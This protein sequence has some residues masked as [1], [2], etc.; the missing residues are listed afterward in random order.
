MLCGTA[1]QAEAAMRELCLRLVQQAYAPA[2][3]LLTAT[4]HACLLP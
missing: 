4:L 3:Q 1:W 2:A